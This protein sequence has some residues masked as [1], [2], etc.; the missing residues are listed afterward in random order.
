[1]DNGYERPPYFRR[2]RS[3]YPS[4]QQQREICGEYFELR[5]MPDVDIEEFLEHIRI[6]TLAS[7]LMWFMWAILAR[8]EVGDKI[9]WGY[10]EYG[11]FRF[12]EYLD[13]KSSIEK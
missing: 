2:I 13:L 4:K 10:E 12:Q 1:M 3:K 9:C 6:C 8:H 11:R 7:H 5:G